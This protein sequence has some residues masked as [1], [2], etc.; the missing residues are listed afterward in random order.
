MKQKIREELLAPEPVTDFDQKLYSG[1]LAS[2]SLKSKSEV[3]I[4]EDKQRKIK[5]RQEKEE[6]AK[7]KLR[8]IQE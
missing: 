5:E 1:Y 4:L 6:A 2:K 3:E 8:M 7:K